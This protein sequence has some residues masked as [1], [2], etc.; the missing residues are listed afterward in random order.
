[1]EEITM[2]IPFDGF[3]ETLYGELLSEEE[4]NFIEDI[5][6][7]EDAGEEVKGRYK[8]VIAL[9][10]EDFGYIDIPPENYKR[11]RE[12]IAQTY[13]KKFNENFKARFGMDLGLKYHHLWSPKEYNFATDEIYCT[14]EKE[15]LPSILEIIKDI[16]GFLEEFTE[17]TRRRYTTTDGHWVK[18]EYEGGYERWDKDNLDENHYYIMLEFLAWKF[19]D[20]LHYAVFYD[21]EEESHGFLWEDL[22]SITNYKN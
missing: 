19:E 5:I 11:A 2:R 14:I 16:E 17:W 10:K 18:D 7:N 4:K 15:K 9:Y 1:M 12:H 13:V 3:Y 20:E 6:E 22:F 8:D 21:V